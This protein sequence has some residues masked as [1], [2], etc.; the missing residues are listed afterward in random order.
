M[1]LPSR[2][3]EQASEKVSIVWL[4]LYA[5]QRK[6]RGLYLALVKSK[7]TYDNDDGLNFILKMPYY[8]FLLK[9]S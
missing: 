6:G 1:A 3:I 2:S 4:R 8:N 9:S 5:A 7:A